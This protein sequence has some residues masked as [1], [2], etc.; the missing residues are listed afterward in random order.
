MC[1]RH[2][3][4]AQRTQSRSA[5]AHKMAL[6][7]RSRRHRSRT[8]PQ[9]KIRARTISEEGRPCNGEGRGELPS[10]LVAQKAGCYDEVVM[11]KFRMK[12][13]SE[14]SMGVVSAFLGGCAISMLCE[15][16]HSGTV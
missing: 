13:E 2:R 6:S 7:S 16:A 11:E 4:E 8:P 14:A 9:R 12:V 10:Q 3:L 1:T 15:A 5:C